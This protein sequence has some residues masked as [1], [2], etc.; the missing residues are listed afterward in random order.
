MTL[1]P[2]GLP[3]DPI[4]DLAGFADVSEDH[5]AVGDGV[6]NDT[7]AVQAAIDTGLN[8]FFPPGTYLVDE[9]NMGE[10]DV[11]WL[12]YG[13]TLKRRNL[14]TTPENTY[15]A[16][17]RDCENFRCY[18]LAIDFNHI[19]RFGGF[20]F[21]GVD[22]LWI[23]DCHFHDSDLNSS[24]SSFDHYA[25]VIQ[26][27][28]DVQVIGNR[29]E[30][31]EFAEINN[32]ERVRVA[33]NVIHRAAGTAAI[34]MFAVAS[35]YTF[36]DI[37]IVDNVVIDPRKRG[38]MFQHESGGP[39]NVVIRNV[40]IARNYVAHLTTTAD[41]GS[42]MIDFTTAAATGSG[43]TLDGVEI[44]DNICFAALTLATRTVAHIRV[45][46]VSGNVWAGMRVARNTVHANTTD[47]AMDL[48]SISSGEVHDNRVDGTATDGI[49]LHTLTGCSV[50]R[51]RAK[52]TTNAFGLISSGGTNIVTGNR[53]I[54][55]PTNVWH[56]SSAAASGDVI[57]P[58]AGAKSVA[59][60]ATLTLPLDSGDVVTVTGSTTITSI[61][62]TGLA[63]RRITFVWG[64]A[65]TFD[66]TDGSNLKL[67][68]NI[69]TH[70]ADDAVTLACDG[71]NWYAA[72]PGS[73][74]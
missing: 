55:S 46:H 52:A 5:G 54:G 35:G 6:T 50:A 14:G 29:S 21:D 51:N 60:A 31:V 8:V 30:D 64:A 25:L 11:T 49:Q 57:E 1:K 7:A 40:R 43:N 74:N 59:S 66:M 45:R 38:I 42:R 32:C 73:V 39:D 34:G 44:V 20:N 63:G 15:V 3:N 2:P 9:V 69:T 16:D 28:T 33:E 47:W 10:S 71:T 65:A 68:A 41:A 56:T 12:G 19:E 24:W 18:G 22:G 23:K 58:T 62:A 26:N 27:C 67:A 70:D 13:A 61:T 48:R 36:K 72:S 4:G 17:V 37:E 53:P